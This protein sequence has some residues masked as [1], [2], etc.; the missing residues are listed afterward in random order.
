MKKGYL[1]K[2]IGFMLILIILGGCGLN[3]T[4][5]DKEEIKRKAEQVGI[6]YF[7]KNYDADVVFTEYK[8]MPSYIDNTVG[9]YGH[10]KGESEQS[11]FLMLNYRNFEV[12]DG[13][14][15]EGFLER[16]PLI[17]EQGNGF[18]FREQSE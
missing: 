3:K 14:V 18:T 1:R 12:I 17:H 7:K 8:V 6:E 9:I 2:I 11:I 16:Y 5:S 13:I 10:I 15:P 4:N